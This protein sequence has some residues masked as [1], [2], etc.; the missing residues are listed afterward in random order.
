[1]IFTIILILI[2]VLLIYS[3]FVD[4][5]IINNSEEFGVMDQLA[6]TRSYYPSY[7]Y[8]YGRY[9]LSGDP[10]VWNNPTRV[11]SYYPYYYPYYYDYFGGWYRW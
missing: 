7:Y 10:F 9:G 8:P 1:M 6:S 4:M 11:S 5:K 3:S 2:A